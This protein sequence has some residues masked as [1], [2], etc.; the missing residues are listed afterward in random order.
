MTSLS[1]VISVN[2]GMQKESGGEGRGKRGQ[3]HREGKKKKKVITGNTQYY[4]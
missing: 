2:L 1:E 4:M 3:K